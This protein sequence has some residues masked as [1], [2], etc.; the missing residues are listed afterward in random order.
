MSRPTYG[1]VGVSIGDMLRDGRD[2]LIRMR[3]QTE[4]AEES[5]QAR[6]EAEAEARHEDPSYGVLM[7][8]YPLTRQWSGEV[9]GRT[10]GGE[11]PRRFGGSQAKVLSELRIAFAH[12][13]VKERQVSGDHKTRW[14]AALDRAARL[15]LYVADTVRS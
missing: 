6:D 1:T 15:R 13:L 8:Q 14:R 3:K 5:G 12:G 11:L 4:R 2:D 10:V 7:R 9:V